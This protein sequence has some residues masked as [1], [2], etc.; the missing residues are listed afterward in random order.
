MA[1]WPYGTLRM[2]VCPR[3]NDRND[4]SL[5]PAARSVPGM[6]GGRGAASSDNCDSAKTPSGQLLVIYEH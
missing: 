6:F 3:V 1:T 5:I 4:R 2:A